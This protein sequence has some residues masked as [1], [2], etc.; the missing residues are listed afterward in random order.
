[1]T[2]QLRRPLVVGGVLLALTFSAFDLLNHLLGEVGSSLLVMGAIG[3][4]VWWFRRRSPKPPQL[5]AAATPV[6]LAT[7]QKTLSEAERVITQ[8]E[9]EVSTQTEPAAIALKPH[10]PLL[11]LQM[12]QIA[13][14]VYRQEIRLV[15]LGGK[16]S[17][18]T[19]LAQL[20]QT[21]WVGQISQKVC[22]GEAPSF[23][24]ISATGLSAERI[25]LQQAMAGDLVLFVVTGDL[26]ESEFQTVKQLV[27][28]KR[29][30]LVFN[31]QDQYAPADRQVILSK[32]QERVQGILPK[33][34]VVAIAAAPNPIK[35][36]QH[37]EDG[38]VQER[39]E[40][41]SPAI[42]ALTQRLETI[43]IQESKQLV[44]ASSLGNAIA[45]KTQAK[46]V[47]NDLRRVRAMPIVEQFQWIA[48]A[49]AFASPLPT[50][51]VLATAAINAQMI[52]DLGAIYQQQFSLQ[53]AQ[54][55][56]TTLGSLM[57]KLGLVEL[58]TRVISGFLKSNAVT[59]IAGGCL[60]GISAAYLTHLA[61]LSLI[62]YFYTQEPNLTPAEAP[63]LAIERFSQ[64]LQAVFQRNQQLTFLQSFV[65]Q[66]IN[67]LAP[68]FQSS[69]NSS[70]PLSTP[71]VSLPMSHSPVFAAKPKILDE[72]G[73]GV[74]LSL[75]SLD[76]TTLPPT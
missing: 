62:E 65:S 3:T 12:T 71:Q 64:I 4:G 52:L 59:Y 57:L 61:G 1:M 63:P 31:K 5:S 72:N 10:L 49:T 40:E 68:V 32:L 15:V 9:V 7:L 20:L 37:Q 51:D 47:L 70:L 48:A 42:A 58:S 39:M 18:K 75:P 14:E 19:I 46:T 73:T 36:R 45:L 74:R 67:H 60:Q 23:S 53:Q 33:E 41:Q 55:I 8:L 17:G 11:Q 28:A 21:T 44:L 56:A 35:V 24:P 25:A 43:L 38:S 13:Q 69:T 76:S 34:D 30:L 27:T 6:D 66:A 22:L 2:E 29:T 50:L 26:T 16:S 54:K